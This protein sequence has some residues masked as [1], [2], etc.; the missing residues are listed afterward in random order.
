MKITNKTLL[1]I[2]ECM[3][4]MAPRDDD[5]FSLGFAGDT[6]NTA[7]YA[8]RLLPD[9][10]SVAYGT[11]VGNDA[12]SDRMCAFMEREGIET[13]RIVRVPDRTVG[14]YMIEL[15]NGERSFSYWRG[16]SAART[17]GDDAGRLETL[18]GG[19]GVLFFSGITLAILPPDARSLFCNAVAR[20][21][22]NGAVVAF[23][24]N[25][26]PRLWED[27]ETMRAGLMQGASVAD[28]VLPS[29]DEEA[30]C[31]DDADPSRT[32]DRYRDAGARIVVVKDGSRPVTLFD[33]DNPA[34]TF[35]PTPASIV[36]DT[37]AAGDSFAAGFLSGFVQG[38]SL[39]EAVETAMAVA[40]KV[41]QGQ[42]A[43]VDLAEV[44][45]QKTGQT[46]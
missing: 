22:E 2:G 10:W 27:T 20:A 34:Q 3:L 31:F 38:K 21:R 18:L 41:V 6:M 35:T 45:K 24:T 15:E 29:F 9:D 37:T 32:A 40:A 42:G 14:L 30:D 8:R 16:Q 44:P 46:T 39:G 26:R 11:C 25:M 17:L 28:I 4:E 36:R 12:F 19:A 43:L 13:D 33:G 5:A 23:D 7:W 1:C